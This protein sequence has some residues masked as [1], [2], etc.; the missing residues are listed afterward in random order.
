M[1]SQ[2]WLSY[3]DICTTTM[4]MDSESL[5]DMLANDFWKFI[6]TEKEKD[7][8]KSRI[9]TIPWDTGKLNAN[10]LAFYAFA[11]FELWI[12]RSIDLVIKTERITHHG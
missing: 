10:S 6:K 3:G 8:E 11:S 9:G 5:P 1:W 2:V 7:P 12:I 4:N